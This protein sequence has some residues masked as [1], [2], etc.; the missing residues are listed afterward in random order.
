[1]TKV[2]ICGITTYDDAKLAL[3]LGADALGFNFVKASKR[4]ISP[5]DAQVIVR[6]LP[7]G[8]WRTGVFVNED[9]AEVERIARIAA[10]DTLQFHG[11]ESPE[12]CRGWKEW[13]VVKALRIGPAAAFADASAYADVD[14]FL[15]DRYSATTHGG[16]GELIPDTDLAR[17]GID[18]S[19]VFLAGG[20]NPDNVGERISRYRPFG[21]DVASGVESE[22]GKKD[23]VLLERFIAAS[24]Q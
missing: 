13:R 14:H 15:L 2:K 24:R 20:L 22:P 4:Y 7:P 5:V 3:D 16:T 23:P 17:L 1:M 11:E 8:A 9:R 10:L 21:V 18:L 6:R 12:Y 19:R